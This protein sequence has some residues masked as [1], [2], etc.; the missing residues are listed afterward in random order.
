MRPQRDDVRKRRKKGFSG[1]G[2]DISSNM[3]EIRKK[4]NEKGD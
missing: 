4:F 1:N 3:R 2:W